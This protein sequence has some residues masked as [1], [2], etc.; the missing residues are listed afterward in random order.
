MYIHIVENLLMY[1]YICIYIYIYIYTYRVE[2]DA[3]GGD[4]GVGAR[5]V[6]HRLH[7]GHRRD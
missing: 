1:V 3:E 6:A 5:Q 7:H 2:A 4:L